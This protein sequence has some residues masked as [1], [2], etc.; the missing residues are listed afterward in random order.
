MLA[1]KTQLGSVWENAIRHKVQVFPYCNQLHTNLSRNTALAG[2][3]TYNRILPRGCVRPW[4][5]Y[6][7]ELIHLL[8]YSLFHTAA[9]RSYHHWNVSSL[10]LRRLVFRMWVCLLLT[11]LHLLH[12]LFFQAVAVGLH[13]LL[14]LLCLVLHR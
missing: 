5:L 2:T 13:K 10:L 3:Q 11:E 1:A 4:Q 12:K 7:C 9:I 8:I 14:E 6:G